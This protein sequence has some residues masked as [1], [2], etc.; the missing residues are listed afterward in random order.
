MKRKDNYEGCG[1]HPPSRKRRA[2]Y[3]SVGQYRCDKQSQG[4]ETDSGV[5]PAAWGKIG[6]DERWQHGVPGP[7]LGRY[8]SFFFASAISRAVAMCLALA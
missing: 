8:H 3:E 6:A 5:F 4:P 1:M 7:A 2:D